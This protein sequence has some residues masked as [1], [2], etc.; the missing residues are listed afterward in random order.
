MSIENYAHLAAQCMVERKPVTL[1]HAPGWQ[2][3][4]NWPLPM[5]K[6]TPAADGSLT[7]N[8]RPL[9]ILEYVDYALGEAAKEAKSE[10]GDLW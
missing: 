2:R 3:P 10:G 8:Y 9:A 1:T 7:Q 6:G 4:T 5:V